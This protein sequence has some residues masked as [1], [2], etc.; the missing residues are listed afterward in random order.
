[1]MQAAEPWHCNNFTSGSGVTSCLTTGR[2]F[3]R[4][5]KVRPVLVV[6]ADVLV[7]QA[8]QMPLIYDDHVVE[9]V[10]A[11]VADPTFG[12]AIL[13]RTAVAG[14]LRLDAEALYCVDHFFIE[15]CAA[16]KDQVARCG[17]VRKRLAQLA[18][19]PVIK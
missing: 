19:G 6:V 9:Q 1:M 10:T 15:L 12:D 8:F 16:I 7:H 5:R 18:G 13:P 2:S 4:Q 3:L 17:V 14:S 11:A